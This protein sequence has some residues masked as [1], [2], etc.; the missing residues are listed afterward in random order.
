MP[1][2]KRRKTAHPYIVRVKGVCGGRPTIKG[3][4]LAVSTVVQCYKDGMTTDEILNAYPQLTPAQL[5]DTLSYYYDHQAAVD[6][7][8]LRAQDEAYWMKRYPP[9]PFKRG[10]AAE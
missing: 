9:G 5:H 7:E 10:N 6:T 4:R 2:A 1:Q 8:I 3:T